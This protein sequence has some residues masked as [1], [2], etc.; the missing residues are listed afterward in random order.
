MRRRSILRRVFKWGAV[1][2][3]LAI[4]LALV[5]SIR[6]GPEWTVGDQ[7]FGLAKG[8]VFWVPLPPAS[9]SPSVLY[10]DPRQSHYYAAAITLDAARSEGRWWHLEI[11][12]SRVLISFWPL[13]LLPATAA[14]FLWYAERRRFGTGACAGCGYDRSGLPV[15]VK[16]PECGK[17][18]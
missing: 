3:F 13:A 7:Y 11:E 6:E 1:A 18:P 15:G 16:C 4:T 17:K 8:A 10:A 12:K 14:A 2:A 9:P 5:Y